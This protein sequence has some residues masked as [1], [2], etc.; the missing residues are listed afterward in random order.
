[1]RS[2]SPERTQCNLV[3]KAQQSGI[4]RLEV[5]TPLSRH[6]V[7]RLYDTSDGWLVTVISCYKP[8]PVG[9]V[10]QQG[11]HSAAPI[12]QNMA[13]KGRGAAD[14]RFHVFFHVFFQIPV[15]FFSRDN[16]E[17]E[18]NRARITSI[19]LCYLGF[20]GPPDWLSRVSVSVGVVQ[21][22]TKL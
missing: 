14:P 16:F 17:L 13:R 9:P 2:W 3:G 21:C 10:G 22:N 6:L 19:V 15:N 5:T 18:T 20:G 7:S 11:V 12:W 1:M 8:D 4:Q